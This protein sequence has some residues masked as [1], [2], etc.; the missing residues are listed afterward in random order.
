M[1]LRARGPLSVTWRC[2]R[3]GSSGAFA[4]TLPRRC[5]WSGR[6]SLRS[7]KCQ[8]RIHVGMPLRS[9]VEIASLNLFGI[10]F[11]DLNDLLLPSHVFR[12]ESIL[13]PDG[14]LLRLHGFLRPNRPK[15]PTKRALPL[16]PSVARTY[17]LQLHNLC[18]YS[19]VCN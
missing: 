14:F 12:H 3:A 18:E 11:A 16:P 17:S 7:W 5:P 19:K 13:F 1:Q 2:H 10:F 9:L 8:P 15:G 4:S 6:E